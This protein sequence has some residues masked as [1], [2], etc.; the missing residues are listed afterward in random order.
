MSRLE[1]IHRPAEGRPAGPPLLF[2]HGAF[3]AAWCWDEH[4]LPWFAARGFE[5]V[6]F[7]FRGHGRS[8]GHAELH[9][10][11]IGDYVDD[12]RQV[13]AGFDRPPVLIGHSMGGYVAQQY[14]ERGGEGAGLVLLASVPPSGLW[15]PGAWLWL[16]RPVLLWQIGTLQWVGNHGATQDMVN[17]ALFNGPEGRTLAKQYMPRMG[18]ES[19]R[20][21]M[22]IYGPALP[23]RR[24]DI[25]VP[26]LVMGAAKDN[27]IPPLSVRETADALGIEA[28]MFENMGHGM[29]LD[30]GWR[31]VAEAI[32]DWLPGGDG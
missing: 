1:V 17:A 7:S 13:V 30:G 24:L 8:E 28:H 22:D 15:G 12:L 21:C 11:G 29:M 31:R 5:S 4:M 32:H 20:A 3:T 19:L 25:E 14:L 18:N 6:A 16:T 10:L 2:L 23:G 27:L 26:A 9:G